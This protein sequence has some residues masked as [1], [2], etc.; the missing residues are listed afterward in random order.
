MAEED[1]RINA[2]E[3]NDITSGRWPLTTERK[4]RYGLL[5]SSRHLVTEV[6]TDDIAGEASQGFGQL[7]ALHF[8][9][10]HVAFPDAKLIFAALG[11]DR[12]AVD[13]IVVEDIHGN[14]YPTDSDS[15]RNRER[16]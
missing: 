4:G 1:R 11:V 3:R 10:F 13:V 8:P 2:A 15:N 5:D 7:H 14:R 9:D 16:R 6:L 12:H